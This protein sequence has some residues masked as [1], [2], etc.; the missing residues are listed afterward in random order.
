MV[1]T[2]AI[3]VDNTACISNTILLKYTKT[4]IDFCLILK[5]PIWF[6]SMP[7]YIQYIIYI[8]TLKEC[9]VSDWSVNSF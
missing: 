3:L 6:T 7:H 9:S 2:K 5:F 8:F 1:I 4:K